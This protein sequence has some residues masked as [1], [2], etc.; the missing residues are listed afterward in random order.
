MHCRARNIAIFA[1]A[2][3]ALSANAWAANL[4]TNPDFD[5]DTNGWSAMAGGSIALE[6]SDGSP[7]AP[8][9][10]ITTAGGSVARAD[11]A[12]ITVTGGQNYDLTFNQKSNDVA[13]GSVTYYSDSACTQYVSF[14]NPA[15]FAASLSNGWSHETL[16]NFTI[17][18]GVGS[19]QVEISVSAG[20][21]S[22]ATAL[23][24]HVRFG[25][26]GSAPVT[27]QSFQVQ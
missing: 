25:P 13:A 15:S 7:G 22:T 8:S 12:C 3:L 24:D 6:T 21:A 2:T 26:A 4:V 23:V 9:L 1:A 19:V 11:S 17:P 27:L 5:T 20:G 14:S 10:Q 18:T 16:N